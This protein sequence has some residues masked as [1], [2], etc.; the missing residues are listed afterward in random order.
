MKYA[1]LSIQTGPISCLSGAFEDIAWASEL[2]TALLDCITPASS[3]LKI[4]RGTL[5]LGF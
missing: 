4:K 3:I 1:I 2:E 5:Q